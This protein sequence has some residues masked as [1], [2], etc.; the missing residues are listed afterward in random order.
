[1]P[2]KFD[3]ENVD[4]GNVKFGTSGLH[5]FQKWNLLNGPSWPPYLMHNE[6]NNRHMWSCR[7]TT[8]MVLNSVDVTD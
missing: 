4:F 2:Q 1:M 8:Q 6:I 3:F 5:I 7:R